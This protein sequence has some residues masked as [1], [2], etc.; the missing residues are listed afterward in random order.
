M[1]GR[2]RGRLLEKKP[3]E[4]LI[5]TGGIAYEIQAPMTTFYCLPVVGE[6]TIL[7][8]HLVV[9]EDQHQLFGFAKQEERSLFRLLIKVNGVGPKLALT[10]L[11]NFEPNDFVQCILKEDENALV[12]IPGIGKKTAQRLLLDMRD[13]VADWFTDK[14]SA[15]Q[16]EIAITLKPTP[17]NFIEEAISALVSLGYKPQ[18]ASRAVHKIKQDDLSCE[19]LIRLA[20]QSFA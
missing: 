7:Y 19:Q 20:L 15:S 8:T 18:E 5:E 3:P 12:R 10:V 16:T 14:T 9:R 2:L 11:S 17:F 6:E 13:R 1:I 4:L